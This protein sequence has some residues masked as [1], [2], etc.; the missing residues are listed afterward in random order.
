M[1]ITI[2]LVLEIEPVAIGSNTLSFD[3]YLELR[4]LSLLIKISAST[5]C[6]QSLFKFLNFY[7]I[8]TFDLVYS[9]LKNINTAPKNL[10]K[11]S[12]FQY[13]HKRMGLGKASVAMF[14][15]L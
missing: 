15:N 5:P 9:M 11:F 3:E 4:L 12:L 13:Y 6:Y 8:E 7:R 10:Q 2:V 1:K 14:M